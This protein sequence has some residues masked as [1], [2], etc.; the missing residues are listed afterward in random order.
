MDRANKMDNSKN[1]VFNKQH[2]VSI[3]RRGLMISLE[4]CYKLIIGPDSGLKP[5]MTKIHIYFGRLEKVLW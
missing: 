4:I 5:K 3:I 1:K 2:I